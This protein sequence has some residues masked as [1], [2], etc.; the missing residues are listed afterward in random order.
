[1]PGERRRLAGDAFH[2][3]AIAADRINIEIEKGRIR[4]VVPR[5]EPARCDRHADAVAA[6][7]AEWTGRGLDAA[8]AAIFRVSRRDAVELAK[9][10]DVVEADRR[11]VGDAVAYDAAY[12]C[13]MKQA[14]KQH[15][16]VACR[17][18]KAVA[19]RPQRVGRVVTKELL[20][21][22]VSDRSQGHR[23]TGVARLRFFYRID[24]QRADRVDTLFVEVVPARRAAGTLLRSGFRPHVASPSEYAESPLK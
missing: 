21:Q 20:P 14:V 4:P 3:V 10:L 7:L 8:G 18:D 17:Q 16:G 24:S 12:P 11:I 1:M 13:Q 5:A 19:V 22:R 23:R 9:I 2:H 6:T 15:G